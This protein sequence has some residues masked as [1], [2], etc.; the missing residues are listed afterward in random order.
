MRIH[1]S[2]STKNAIDNQPYRVVERGKIEVKGKGEM[3]TYFVLCKINEDGK[4]IKCPFMEIFEAQ[5]KAEESSFFEHN[6]KKPLEI[7][8]ESEDVDA[9]PEPEKTDKQADNDSIASRGYSPVMMN[10]VKKSHISLRDTKN[11]S[12][13]EQQPHSQNAIEKCPHMNGVSHHIEILGPNEN[14][15][16]LPNVNFNNNTAENL[17]EKKV[18]I[19]AHK[20]ETNYKYEENG[21]GSSLP[22]VESIPNAH[23]ISMEILESKKLHSVQMNHN[24]S[25]SSLINGKSSGISSSNNT[26]LSKSSQNSTMSK[27][28]KSLAC[29]VI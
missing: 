29:Q 6:E 21:K 18:T 28:N 15:A 2:Q 25:N 5:K 16:N 12:P 8:P 26:D 7:P 9:E 13:L 10:D 3:K 1:I 11:Q 27:K 22:K 23:S 19:S 14:S 24:D 4:S 20:R 17:G